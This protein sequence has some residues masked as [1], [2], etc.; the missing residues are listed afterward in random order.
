MRGKSVSS[1]NLD[2]DNYSKERERWG[3]SVFHAAPP[4]A[5]SFISLSR[6]TYK[7]KTLCPVALLRVLVNSILYIC[8]QLSGSD[9]NLVQEYYRCFF[10]LLRVMDSLER[11]G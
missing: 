9:I 2:N 11:M 10:P 5:H 4:P 1:C 8:K 7:R 3:V 6:N